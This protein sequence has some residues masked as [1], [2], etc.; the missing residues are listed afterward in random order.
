[1]QNGI[2]SFKQ[3]FFFLPFMNHP[4]CSKFCIF[5]CLLYRSN[6]KSLSALKSHIIHDSCTLKYKLCFL[7]VYRTFN[8]TFIR[9][10]EDV[11]YRLLFPILLNF[12]YHFSSLKTISVSFRVCGTLGLPGNHFKSSILLPIS[13]PKTRHESTLHRHTL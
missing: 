5:M 10:Y 4:G 1:M 7:P 12:I 8:F 13:F 2:S 11:F 3:F 9:L 6:K